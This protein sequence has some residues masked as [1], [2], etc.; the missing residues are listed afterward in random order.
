MWHTGADRAASQGIL[1]PAPG[2][3]R[4][5]VPGRLVQT[6]QLDQSVEE[7]RRDLGFDGPRG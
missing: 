5:C 7:L 1:A 6:A 3:E 4:A 2:P